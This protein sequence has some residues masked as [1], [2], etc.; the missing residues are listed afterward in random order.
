MTTPTPEITRG[1]LLRWVAWFGALNAVLF[2]LVGLRYVAAFGLPGGPLATAYMVLAFIGQFA[3]LGVVPSVLLLGPLLAVIPRRGL[4]IPLGVIIGALGLSLIVL[5]TNIFAQYR[6]H[7]SA[8]TVALFDTS[9]WVLTVTVFLALLGFQALLAG[10]VWNFVS[11]SRQRSGVL[12]GLLLTLAWLGGQGIH[13][14]ADATA[15]VPVTSFTRYLP[16]YFPIK[17]KRRLAKLGWVDPE[18]VEKQRLLRQADAPDSGQLLY[19]LSPLQCA[20]P[21]RPLNVLVVLIDALRPDR[22]TAAAMPTVHALAEQGL[23]FTN[24]YSGGNS[25][26][27][28]I[29]SLFYGL[30][31]TYWQTFYDTQRQPVLMEQMLGLDYEVSAFSSVGF[32]S[33]AQIDRTLFAAVDP[34][35]RQVGEASEGRDRNQAITEQWQ[36][37]FANRDTARPFFSFLYYDPG[38]AKDTGTQGGLSGNELQDKIAG[39]DRG[40][41]SIDAD[42]AELLA[43]LEAAGIADDTL[44]LVTGDHGYEFDELGLGYVGH[45]SN[46]GPWQLRTPLIMRWP[47]RDPQRFGQRSAH[48]DVPATLLQEAYGCSNPASDYSSGDNLFAGKSWDWILAGSYNSH[49]IVET[50]KIVVNNPGG[51]IEVLGT[52]YRPQQGLTLDAERLE[53]AVVEMRRFYR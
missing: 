45:A 51:F 30:P 12:V 23:H 15:Y 18:E 22:V 48:Q 47:G 3:V 34:A 37:W 1:L 49:A 46:Y 8:L 33:P 7:L 11:G 44:V 52:D 42:V 31:S 26:R 25:S 4:I 14:W 38:N 40:I 17:A 10:I 36:T 13:I 29:F 21:E 19:P 28:G 24:H 6:F 2:A 53:E 16:A 41:A 20:A 5:D 27:M 35:A 43:D 39:Y 50:D 32:G 9:T